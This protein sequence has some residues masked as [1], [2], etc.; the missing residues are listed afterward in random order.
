MAT[1]TLNKFQYRV[2]NYRDGNSLILC[3]IFSILNN[4]KALSIMSIKV[5]L[6]GIFSIQGTCIPS[7]SLR[8]TAFPVTTTTHLAHGSARKKIEDHFGELSTFAKR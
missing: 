6:P 8:L 3:K 2:K 7:P 4:H 1:L 5:F